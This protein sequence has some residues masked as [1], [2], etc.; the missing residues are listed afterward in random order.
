MVMSWFGAGL[1]V[2]GSVPDRVP[3]FP[4]M[5]AQIAASF[6][7]T[8]AP[9][10][11]GG[12][13]LNTRFLQKRGVEPGVAV[14]GVGLNAV[15]GFVVHIVLLGVFILWAGT[16]TTSAAA[17]GSSTGLS[18]PSARTTLLVVGA[19]V[20]IVAGAWAIPKTRKLA[21]TRLVPLVRDALH[22]IGQLARKPRKLFAL[23]GGSIIVTFGFYG[24]L[25]CAVQAF[26]GGPTP[27]QIGVAYLAAFAVAILAPT[28]G[29]LGAL[30]A[31]LILSF[32]RLG[33]TSEVAV[34][35]VF[36]FRVGTFWLP[37]APG[38]ITFGFLQRRGDI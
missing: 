5:S 9:A 35:S 11:I 30:E 14:A 25:V 24:A 34:S 32:Q 27:A 20:A 23:F 6:V 29:G 21:R 31:A 2:V 7:D 16:D 3:F 13:A 17:G 12:M 28:P 15:A 18:A 38:W 36:L 26:G 33:M 1:G 19:L 10:S 8:L 37:V 22:G 4:V